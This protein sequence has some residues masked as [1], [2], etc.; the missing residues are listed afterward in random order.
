MPVHHF[1]APAAAYVHRFQVQPEDI[2][3]LGH[4]N[5]VV[6]VRWLNQAAIAHSSHVGW[7][8]DACRAAGVIWVV[9]QH[10][11]EYLLPAY[12]GDEVTALTWPETLR[13]ATCA[14]RTLFRRGEQLLASAETSWV[15]LDARASRPR[16]IP[17]E[18]LASYGAEPSSP[19][20][21]SESA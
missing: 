21:R 12:A 14:R 16:R 15:L 20:P 8:M 6:W 2:D 10:D 3:E 9:R 5:N 13:A 1:V 19:R 18:M 4:A 7:G 17:P 11:I